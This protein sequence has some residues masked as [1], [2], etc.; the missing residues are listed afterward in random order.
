MTKDRLMAILRFMLK[1]RS[2][3]ILIEKDEIFLHTDL[4]FAKIKAQEEDHKL[5]CYLEYLAGWSFNKP[6]DLQK[7]AFYLQVD[8]MDHWFSFEG[9]INK[10]Q[11]ILTLIDHV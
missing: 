6:G 10:E 8:G 1:H 4:G 11:G 7:E 5:L 2:E 9:S 3:K